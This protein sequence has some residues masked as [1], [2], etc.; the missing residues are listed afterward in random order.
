MMNPIEGYTLSMTLL[1]FLT[2][3]TAAHYV[4]SELEGLSVQQEILSYGKSSEI[5]FGVEREQMHQLFG[6]TL[7]SSVMRKEILLIKVQQYVLWNGS[8]VCGRK[9]FKLN[10]PFQQPPHGREQRES[11]YST[12]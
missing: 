10:H 7:D 8:E 12:A 3:H 6:I 5:S 1:A 11:S 9:R 2:S 4:L